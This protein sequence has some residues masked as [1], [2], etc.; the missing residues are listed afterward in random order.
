MRTEILNKK[1]TYDFLL[2]CIYASHSD[3]PKYALLSDLVLALD[4]ES[5]KN[6]LTLFE[7]QTIT[8]PSMKELITML[9]AM[10]IQASLSKNND[11]M[12]VVLSALGYKDTQHF[13]KEYKKFR[14]LLTTGKVR[15]G[16]LIDDYPNG[17]QVVN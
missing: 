11:N 8:I 5:F 17:G 16:G 13:P 9:K 15:I 2:A 1:D 7:G 4:E 6:F 12:E 14:K 10:T 3:D